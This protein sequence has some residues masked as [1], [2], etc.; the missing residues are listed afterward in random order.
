MLRIHDEIR[1][2]ITTHPKLIKAD[3]RASN[4]ISSIA[5]LCHG[6]EYLVA[7]NARIVLPK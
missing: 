1:Y 4:P 7:S 5:V 6:F 2:M 3:R